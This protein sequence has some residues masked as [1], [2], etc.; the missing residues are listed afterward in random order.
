MKLTK[1][2]IVKV[3]SENSE[4]EFFGLRHDS[5]VYEIGE[6]VSRSHQWFQDDPTE[7][8]E[9]LPYNAEL[10]LWDGGELDGTC[11][12][13]VTEGGVEKAIKEANKYDGGHLYLIAS[14]EAWGGNDY[15]EVIMPD[16]IV[17]A[18]FE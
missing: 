11:A 18:E 17:V 4:Y 16:A 1:D 2:N 3:I 15:G 9:D 6:E 13:E 8:G 14:R 5:H 10:G 12:V 7:W